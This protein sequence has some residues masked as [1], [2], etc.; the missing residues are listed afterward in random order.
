MPSDA[1]IQRVIDAQREAIRQTDLYEQCEWIIKMA[2]ENGNTPCEGSALTE[3][4]YPGFWETKY[5]ASNN[6]AKLLPAGRA[7]WNAGKEKP[8]A[9]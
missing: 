2:D 6:W 8:N 4:Y 9:K 7:L 5:I 3:Q 1:D